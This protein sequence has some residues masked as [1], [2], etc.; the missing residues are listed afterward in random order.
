MREP[1]LCG[2]GRCTLPLRRALAGARV[3]G[4]LYDPAS[5]ATGLIRGATIA[6]LPP[7]CVSGWHFRSAS[8]SGWP[9][10][11]HGRQLGSLYAGNVAGA[12]AGSILAGFVLLA[13]FGMPAVWC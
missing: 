8:A 7:R 12:F 10:S 3:H 13:Q 6:I 5:A 11:G 1:S 4:S 9:R 2:S